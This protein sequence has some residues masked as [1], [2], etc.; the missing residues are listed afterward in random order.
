MN[1]VIGLGLVILWLLAE[2][3]C[4]WMILRDCKPKQPICY[5]YHV[6][7]EPPTRQ[8]TAESPNFYEKDE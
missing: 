2:A 3:I 7:D 4:I 6:A 8:G 5:G 1:I